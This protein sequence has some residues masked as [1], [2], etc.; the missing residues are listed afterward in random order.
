MSIETAFQS[1]Q[2]QLGQLKEEFGELRVNA[3]EF[4]P[5]SRAGRRKNGQPTPQAPPPVNT[6]ADQAA[7][8]QGELDEALQAA[9][10]AAQAVRHPRNLIEAQ[11]A[12]ISIQRAL[13]KTLRKFLEEVAAYEPLSLLDHMGRELGEGWPKWTG[14]IRSI[15][16]D[17][18]ERLLESFHALAECWQELAEKLAANSVS[19]QTTNIGQQITA[20][21]PNSVHE[22]T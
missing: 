12:V 11:I 14:L 9:H 4:Y 18:R 22:F 6:L 15:V 8:L 21:E 3:E 20:S 1:L 2:R 17:C 19:L 13:N 5:V 10:K 7:D 16:N